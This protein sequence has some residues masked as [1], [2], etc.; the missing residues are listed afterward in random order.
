VRCGVRDETKD[1]KLLV[2]NVVRETM[3][4]VVVSNEGRTEEEEKTCGSGMAVVCG[5]MERRSAVRGMRR[6]RE[7]D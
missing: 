2:G 5:Q 4:G 6:S 1:P 3:S 7:S